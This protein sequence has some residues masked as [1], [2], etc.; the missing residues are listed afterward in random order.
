MLHERLECYRR[1]VELAEGF[2]KE[3]ATWPRG[4][5]YLSDQLKRAMA[6]AVLNLAEGNARRNPADRRRFFEISR[7][8]LVE[9]GACVD[10]SKA[11][12]LTCHSKA[13]QFK[14]EIHLISRMIFGL[15]RNEDNKMDNCER[16]TAN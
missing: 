8:S 1:L 15:I 5:G 14:G 6:S 11:F 10:L 12:G 2:S 13:S 16:R 9:V 3:G 7:A 4:Y